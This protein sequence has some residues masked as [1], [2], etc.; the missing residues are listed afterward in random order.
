MD[1]TTSI[2]VKSPI[3]RSTIIINASGGGDYTHIQWA[4]DNATDGDTIVVEPGE[5]FENLLIENSISLIGQDQRNTTIV[6]ADEMDVISI[7]SSFVKISGFTIVGKGVSQGAQNAGIGMWNVSNCRIENNTIINNYE[8]ISI[9]RSLNISINNNTLLNNGIYLSPFESDPNYWSSHTVSITNKVNG[10]PLYYLKNKVGGIVPLDAGQVILI[11][12][13]NVE[14]IDQN[15]TNSTIGITL[16]L[17]SYNTIANNTC[18]F[19]KENGIALYQ[20]HNNSIINNNC[21]KNEHAGIELI[22]SNDNRISDNNCSNNKGYYDGGGGINLI[23]SLNNTLEKNICSNNDYFG[24]KSDFAHHIIKD[25]ICDSNSYGIHLSGSNQYVINNSCNSNEESGIYVYVPGYS[26]IAENRCLNNGDGIEIRHSGYNRVINNTCLFNDDSGIEIDE[27]MMYI[28]DFPT[29]LLFY[30]QNNFLKNNNCSYNDYGIKVVQ[31]VNNTIKKNICFSNKQDGIYLKGIPSDY[32]KWLCSERNAIINNSIVNNVGYG[33]NLEVGSGNNTIS[34]NNLHE[35]N[36]GEIQGS[37]NGTN[38][39]WNVSRRGNYW[40][41]WISPDSDGNAVVDIPYSISGLSYSK[42]YYPLLSDFDP[43]KP[44]ADAGPDISITEN[45]THLFNASQSYSDIGIMN[46][47]WV[48]EYN[49]KV[50][51]LFGVNPFFRF[52]IQG[53][54]TVTLSVTDSQGNRAEDGLRITVHPRDGEIPQDDDD[55]DGG[56]EQDEKGMSKYIITGIIVLALIGVIIG[57]FMIYI[58]KRKTK[59]QTEDDDFGR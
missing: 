58:R 38:N 37:D 41:D 3:T 31:G 13:T 30:D 20:S 52:D 10:N 9:I 51:K 54:Y 27:T 32:H 11:N 4:I 26:I 33:I 39:H 21:N 45:T 23:S 24:I 15:I 35:N 12:C 18:R 22:D 57:I 49:S 53:E 36:R 42:D 34:L 47:T 7:R 29:I 46:Y 6:S 50:V 56:E 40:S 48:F 28:I 8:G 59:D 55:S 19:Q 2:P 14:I 17:S 44:V 25:N 43:S 16:A 5:Y 1:S